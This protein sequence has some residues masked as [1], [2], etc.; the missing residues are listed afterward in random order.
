MPVWYFTQHR[1]RMRTP[2]QPDEE[3][4]Y[5]SQRSDNGGQA[6]LGTGLALDAREVT[7]M[8]YLFAILAAAV[9][10]FAVKLFL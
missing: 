7:V 10:A 5:N 1:G 8:R 9:V 3:F 4:F 6:R 2:E